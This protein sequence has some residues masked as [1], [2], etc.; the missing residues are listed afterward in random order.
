LSLSQ[1]SRAEVCT[2][3]M[4]DVRNSSA[5]SPQRRQPISRPTSCAT[6]RLS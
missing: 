3:T 2:D 5:M 6:K 1:A 4:S